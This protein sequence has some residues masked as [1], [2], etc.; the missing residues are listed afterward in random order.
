MMGLCCILK[1]KVTLS[2]T[3]DYVLELA[4]CAATFFCFALTGTDCYLGAKM[5]KMP[6]IKWLTRCCSETLTY[7]FHME[8]SNRLTVVIW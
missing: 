6:L 2:D 1:V 4:G 5:Q 7:Q 8:G 3:P